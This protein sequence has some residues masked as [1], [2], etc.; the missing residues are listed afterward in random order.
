M[1]IIVTGGAGFIGSHLCDSLIAEGHNVT[2]VDNFLT[3]SH[4]NVSHLLENPLFRVL[5]HDVTR[6][7]NLPSDA[8]FH[9]ASPASPEDYRA[10]PIE[11][12]LTNSLGTYHL[13]ELAQSNGAKFLLA[14]T[15]EAYGDP[16]EHPQTED[17][18]GNVNPVGPRSCYDESKRFAESL[19][20]EYVRQRDVDARI[21]RIFNTYG[22]RNSPTDGRV[23]PNFITQA[24]EGKP[25]TV[26]GD[27]L[28]TRSICYVSDMVSGLERALLTPGTKGKIFNL[29]NP[30]E[31]TVLDLA[32]VIMGLCGVQLPLCY[33][34]LPA[35]DPTRRCPD[36][37]RAKQQLGWEPIV[38]VE[39]G[40]AQSIAWFRREREESREE[41]LKTL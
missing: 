32:H 9:L 26:Y 20:M 24:L 13:L 29:G 12:Q 35:D 15:S 40:L 36:I 3:G 11:T 23:V 22:P 34:P 39:E 21:V 4:D 28:Q 38:S 1:R 17:Y 41:R 30:D 5:E 14:S 18:W 37:T 8:I 27:G 7:L 25:L 33:L 16:T 6:P 10:Y 31:R 19:A 2:A